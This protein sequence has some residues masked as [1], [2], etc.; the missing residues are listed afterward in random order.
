MLSLEI[1][2]PVLYISH[3]NVLIILLVFHCIKDLVIHQNDMIQNI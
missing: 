3:V 1:G 2:Y